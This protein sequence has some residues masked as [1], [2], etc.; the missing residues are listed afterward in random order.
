MTR[1]TIICDQCG[2]TLDHKRAAFRLITV[3]LAV[4]ME[5]DLCSPACLIAMGERYKKRRPRSTC[6]RFRG[7]RRAAQL[8]AGRRTESWSAECYRDVN[9]LKIRGVGRDLSARM[10]ND[11]GMNKQFVTLNLPKIDMSDVVDV[12][13]RSLYAAVQVLAVQHAIAFAKLA[14]IEAKLGLPSTRDDETHPQT[15]EGTA[16]WEALEP[17]VERL[18]KRTLDLVVGNVKAEMDREK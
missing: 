4:A 10:R 13:V 16:R 18:Y 9:G 7:A 8:I 17:E 14:E 1:V 5:A 3:R 11:P 12:H 15:A 6:R 2:A